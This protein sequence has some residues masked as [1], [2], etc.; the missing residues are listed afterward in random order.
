[1]SQRKFMMLMGNLSPLKQLLGYEQ[2]RKFVSPPVC[3]F[4]LPLSEGQWPW[5]QLVV[6]PLSLLSG[7]CCGEF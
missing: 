7:T 6:S 1:M 3:G 2:G 4:P 5:V